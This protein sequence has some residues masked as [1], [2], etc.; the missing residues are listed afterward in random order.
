[1]ST[2]M[3]EKV[4]FRH[5][6]ICVW[7]QSWR[8]KLSLDMIKYVFKYN[9]EGESW[10]YTW[11]NMCLSTIMKEK[12]EFRHDQIWVWVQSWRKKLSLY[13]TKYVFKYNHEGKSWVYT[14]RNMSLSTI[15]KWMCFVREYDSSLMPMY[16]KKHKHKIKY[17]YI[18]IY[19]FLNINES[20]KLTTLK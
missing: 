20:K 14:Q 3:K 10:V 9:H 2:I 19:T 6:Q 5:D 13:M 11:R 1:L 7:V 17:I 18:Y 4:K 12:V 8:R 16:Y 15:M